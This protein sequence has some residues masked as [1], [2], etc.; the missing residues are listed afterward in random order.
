MDI[1]E[2]IDKI[3][4]IA[5]ITLCGLFVILICSIVPSF[6]YIAYVENAPLGIIIFLSIFA[7]IFDVWV[8][9]E[10]LNPYKNW[11]V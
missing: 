7:L 4:R 10:I 2:L 5:G 3:N 9:T 1:E 11:V 8:I 6:V